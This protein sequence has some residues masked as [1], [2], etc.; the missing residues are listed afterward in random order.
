[1]ADPNPQQGDAG[2]APGNGQPEMPDD[3]ETL[4]AKYQALERQ[5]GT[6]INER[7][8]IAD[9]RQKLVDGMKRWNSIE[10]EHGV[11][12]D[13]VK[14][15]LAQQQES[16]LKAARERGE[17]DV[18]LANQRKK[19]EHDISEKDKAIAKSRAFIDQLTIDQALSV[20]LDKA[21]VDPRL[22]TGLAALVRDKLKRLED[23]ED[24]HRYVIV[25][26]IGGNEMPLADY[27]RQQAET[28][29]EFAAYLKPS[30]ASGG[31]ASTGRGIAG[32][33]KPRSKMSVAEKAQVFDRMLR[34]HG[35]DAKAAQAAF[36]SLPL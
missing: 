20:E 31:G 5:V 22:K 34:E 2:K 32:K 33:T 6:L 28:D 30:Q 13:Q 29:P 4:K 9:D 8:K 16:T 14:A 7:K 17:V 24:E 35:G 11:D 21:G 36:L 15:L 23:P 27:V 26:Q 12:A 19:F 18:L 25:A 1:M 10:Q 3:V